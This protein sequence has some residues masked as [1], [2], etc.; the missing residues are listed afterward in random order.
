M[1]SA[2]ATTKPKVL[3]KFTSELA[4][5]AEKAAADAEKLLSGGRRWVRGVRR[6]S[7]G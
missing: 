3:Q 2:R 4:D 6:P 7:P 5:L 1:R